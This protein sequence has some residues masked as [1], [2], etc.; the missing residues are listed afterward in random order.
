M[1]TLEIQNGGQTENYILNKYAQSS[2]V[3]IMQKV[4]GSM[5]LCSVCV[6]YDNPVQEDFIPLTIQYIEKMYAI[7]KIPQGFVKKEGKP[8]ESEILISRLIDR[9]LRPLFPKKFPYPVQMSLLVLSYDGKSD[10]CKD[11]LNLAGISLFCSSIP[12]NCQYIPVGVRMV[13][14]NEIAL[15]TNLISL[16]DSSLD[17]FVSG[18]YADSEDSKT[19]SIAQLTMIEMQVLKTTTQN[20]DSDSYQNVESS[21]NVNNITEQSN[22]IPKELLLDSILFARKHIAQI[23]KLYTHC[24]RSFVKTKF[25]LQTRM[26]SDSLLKQKI[27][28]EF[29]EEIK[30]CLL[31]DSKS[32][33]KIHFN[34]LLTSIKNHY[35]S[36]E[37]THMMNADSISIESHVESIKR[38]IMRE[39]ILKGGVRADGRK[40]K[41]IRPLNIE[42]NPLPFAH[43][44]ACFTRGET[45]ALVTCTLGSQSDA[46]IEDTIITQ[47]KK[48]IFFH[49]NFPPFCVGEAAPIGASSRREIGHGN[50]ALKAIESN[51]LDTPST[52][53]IVSEI[54]QSN[55]SSSMASVCGATL[56]MLGAGVKMHN[57]VAGIAMGLIYESKSN[58]VILS[59]IMGLEDHDGDMD[60]KIAGNEKGFTALQLDIK[61]DSI[62]QEILAESFT[63]AQEGLFSILESMRQVSIQPNYDLLPQSLDFTVNTARIPDIIGQG[64]RTIKEIITKFRISINFNKE[65]G[66]VILNGAS[67]D[68]LHEAKEYIF[69]ILKKKERKEMFYKVDTVH[70][71]VVKKILDFGIF[72]ELP[73]GGNGLLRIPSA[74]TELDIGQTVRVKV[75]SNINGKVELGL[76]SE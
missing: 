36:L 32:E 56:A 6:D 12:L 68:I 29:S 72:V 67:Q 13:K 26:N 76:F 73:Q 8:S 45:Q 40:P 59:D 19:E 20:T 75:L 14:H 24:F 41:Q 46:Q 22:E 23:S 43:G 3:S 30:Q 44:S 70:D 21:D 48:K 38:D 42:S 62:S 17:L 57:M 9:S 58:F 63:Q 15:A 2:D 53:R 1:R 18:V 28:N 55:G 49:Y 27:A 47:T 52:L 10:V 11:A 71:G 69:E 16:Q 7:G 61:I 50:L 4:G 35:E 65:K 33:R 60:F 51:V 25:L 64:G 34:K 5:I 37:D 66:I 54:L 31:V 39:M 74:N